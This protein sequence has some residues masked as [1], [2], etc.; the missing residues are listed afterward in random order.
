MQ[1]IIAAAAYFMLTCPGE[2]PGP[3]EIVEVE[4]E[5]VKAF[6]PTRKK[7]GCLFTPALTQPGARAF[8]MLRD[9]QTRE[10]KDRVEIP[11]PFVE[12]SP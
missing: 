2:W 7:T 5:Q 10:L 1:L 4:I 11:G 6:V 8:C 9:A 12:C 3:S